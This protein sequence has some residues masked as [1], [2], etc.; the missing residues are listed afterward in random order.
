M[1]T[2]AAVK[3]NLLFAVLAG[4]LMFD[5][6]FMQL[7]IPPG[8]FGVPV[9]EM[10]LIFALTTSDVPLALIRM[11]AV[12]TLLP[13]LLWWGY[14]LV[15]AAV[16][17]VDYGM[18]AA[19]DA[20]QLIESLYVIVG[21]TI[22]GTPGA[23]QRMT[24]YLPVLLAVTCI[25][26][27]GYVYEPEIQAMSPSVIGAA[28]ETVP[29]F[30][31]YALT[32]TIMLWTAFYCLIGPVGRLWRH[33]RVPIAGGLI[34][35]VIVVVQAR[36]TYLQLLG[37]A[38]LL[39]VFRPRALGRLAVAIPILFIVVGIIT[40]FDLHVAGRLTDKISF[41]FLFQHF[42]A[43]IG[44][45]AHDSG[46]L[47]QA[48]QGVDMR[49]DWW[50]TIYDRLTGDPVTFLT[51]L[52]YGIPLTNFHDELGDIVREPHNSYISVAARLGML[53]FGLWI[54]IQ[55]ALVGAWMRVYRSCRRAQWSDGETFLLMILAFAVLVFIAAIGEDTL[56]K[57]YYAIPFYCFWGVAL[58]M[59]YALQ[60][61]QAALAAQPATRPVGGFISNAGPSWR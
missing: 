44:I 31:S 35:F 13:F 54:W 19:R 23:V 5:Y 10:F 6:P 8:G 56:E 61:R 32:G 11:S 33:W 34:A 45:G 41:D 18:W 57:P 14:G 49:L 53:G 21:F 28:R 59:A 9:G 40:L 50:Q 20:T 16:D 27:L 1:T 39:L 24:R 37:L 12:V 3:Q 58:R 30:G 7:R 36:T 25:Y 51:G 47:G 17:S 22:A 43:I 48:A 38:A 52:G 26:G 46:V 29:L 42:E 55:A 15:R 4:Y 60:A 2:L